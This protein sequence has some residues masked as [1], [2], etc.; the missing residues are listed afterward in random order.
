VT[1]PR[2][3]GPRPSVWRRWIGFWLRA[4]PRAFRE[5]FGAD[6]A[7]QYHDRRPSPAAAVAVAID[8]L[9][10]GLG[11]R[12]DDVRGDRSAR[13][14]SPRGLAAAIGGW[15]RDLVVGARMLRRRPG[16]SLAM[17]VTLGLAAGLAAAVFAIVDATLVRALPYAEP[18]QIV[19]VGSQ[20]TGFDHSAVSAPEY[21]D[22]RER[23]RTL[24]HV[25]L[26]R[27]Q[28]V[29]AGDGPAGPERLEAARV[30][31]SFFDVLGVPAAYGRVYREAD[32]PT[33]RADVAV[34]SH[35]LW[36]R[37][38]GRSA[39]AIGAVIRLDDRPFTILG[40]M[41]ASYALPE[42][43]IDVWL[44]LVVDRATAGGRGAHT[45]RVLARVR[46]GVDVA[47]AGR[48]LAQIG[49]RL[50]A[51]YPGTYPAGSGWGVSVKPLRDVLVGDVRAPLRLLL[52]AVLFVLLIAAT[53]VSGLLLAR[54]DDR[55]AELATRAALGASRFRLVRQFVA[56]GAVLGFIGATLALGVAALLLRAL[57]AGLPEAVVAP[58]AGVADARVL[59]FAFAAT[60]LAGAAAA[61]AAILAARG[62]AA[63]DLTTHH[64]VSASRAVRRTRAAFVTA[65]I[66]LAFLLLVGSGLTIRRFAHL[67][68][69]SPGVV[70]R[71][72]ATARVSLP[73]ARYDDLPKVR[74]FYD[75]L[76][77]SLESAPGM[78]ASGAV[79]LLPLSGWTSDFNFGVE[80]HVP[81]A[82]G[83]EP[84]AQARIVAGRY[85]EA[86]GMPMREGRAFDG[87][88]RTAGEMV[89]IVSESLGRLYWPDGD[90]VGRRIKLWSLDDPG[91]F[92]TIVGIVAD[93]RHNGPDAP[94]P[95]ILYL[96]ASQ[97]LQRTMT[98]V[99]RGDGAPPSP[100]LIAERVRALDPTQP[101]FD[102]RSMEGWLAQAI[103][104]PRF[105][106]QLLSVFAGTAMILATLGVYTVMSQVVTGRMKELGIRVALGASPGKVVRHIAGRGLALTI[107]G[108]AIG[109]AGTALAS[110]YAA[111]LL[112]GIERF[113]V[114]VY[115]VAAVV[116]GGAATL[117]S[118]LPARRVLRLDPLRA[119]RAE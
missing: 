112:H 12:W 61:A 56:E 111:S 91:P 50:Q 62:G 35:A 23:A 19:S 57:D 95:P 97:H 21:L 99:A 22:Y 96:P 5:S 20:W 71:D 52:A 26:I 114:V 63:A 84:N 68:A 98:V 108:L 76:L 100:R 43:T 8:L 117:A 87:R 67:L 4:Y 73:A 79:S 75:D 6:L 102:E 51:E 15:W 81:A 69:V 78:R 25:A 85:F 33:G 7:R 90:A 13:G 77:S 74:Q 45:A 101:V 83:V 27:G 93:V 39:D 32:A 3:S 113:D 16:S 107:A 53:N 110:G 31:A 65:Q 2:A 28:N 17:V 105:N 66:A 109:G 86:L 14:T 42:P 60:A 54:T 37:R 38:F 80:G 46:E 59:L 44:P 30:T 64:R 72:V 94:A 118:V 1:P 92:R 18:G 89:A 11:T 115:A 70:T 88:D 41:P 47:A 10:G 40:V 58:A 104:Q 119:L 103:A 24:A 34:I 106:L 48:E 49:A 82:P 116:L 29:T 9:R 36:T 55:R